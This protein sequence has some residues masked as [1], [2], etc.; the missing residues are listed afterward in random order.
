MDRTALE[1]A[2]MVGHGYKSD[3]IGNLFPQDARASSVAA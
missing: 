3:A 1:L 2:F